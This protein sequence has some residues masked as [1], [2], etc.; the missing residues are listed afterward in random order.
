MQIA[1]HLQLLRY[2]FYSL[3]QYCELTGVYAFSNRLC[4]VRRVLLKLGVVYTS[5]VIS[6][7]LRYIGCRHSLL[8]RKSH[9]LAE[10]STL[11]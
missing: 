3:N 8:L 4:C 6:C 9:I 10:Y 1:T 5:D 2:V 7:L 11:F